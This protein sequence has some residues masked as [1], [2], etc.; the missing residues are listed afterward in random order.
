MAA[1]SLTRDERA[2]RTPRQHRT[3]G[4]CVDRCASSEANVRPFSTAPR[5]PPPPPPETNAGVG[6]QSD[7]R[8]MLV[9]LAVLACSR[10]AH[11]RSANFLP[12][13]KRKHE[14]HSSWAPIG[15]R[16]RTSAAHR[17][18]ARVPGTSLD[19]TCGSAALKHSS[20]APKLRT[21]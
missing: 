21:L 19:P 9:D 14:L 10:R 2:S 17:V 7:P 12:R 3:G 5:P 16:H 8:S 15:S 6:C 18:H 13:V 11:A 4:R 20:R 1:G